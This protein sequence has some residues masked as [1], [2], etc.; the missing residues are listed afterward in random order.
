VSLNR[1][2]IVYFYQSVDGLLQFI[3]LNFNISTYYLPTLP[4]L[5]LNELVH[6]EQI[7]NRH[8][9]TVTFQ[10]FNLNKLR[11][12]MHLPTKCKYIQISREMFGTKSTVNDQ[13]RFDWVFWICPNVTF[14]WNIINYFSEFQI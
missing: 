13:K 6:L 7:V 4:R 12:A 9:F 14:R 2:E 11:H 1:A 5:I 8:I 3:V 10:Y